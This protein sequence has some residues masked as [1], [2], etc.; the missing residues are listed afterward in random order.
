MSKIFLILSIFFLGLWLIGGSL[1]YANKFGIPIQNIALSGVFPVL[2]VTDGDFKITSRSNFHFRHSCDK[3]VVPWETEKSLK[4]LVKYLDQHPSRNLVLTGN[5]SPV[6]QNDTRYLDLG[7]ARSDAIRNLLI[8]FD[9][10]K[11]DIIIQSK[12]C[13]GLKFNND[14][15]F[16]GVRFS[17]E[18]KID[19]IRSKT[20]EEKLVKTSRTIEKIRPLN[21]YYDNNTEFVQNSTQL[22]AYLGNLN[23]YLKK[24]PTSKVLLIGHTDNVGTSDQ[25]KLL[26]K[27]RAF[28]VKSLME[29]FG[30][31]AKQIKVDY[32]GD[33]RPL[34]S[35][36]TNN[37]RKKNRRVEVR[38]IN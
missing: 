10:K 3:V 23:S 36:A 7:L 37:G 24:H 16:D 29:E 22:N 18:Q 14:L 15:L 1:G 6:E 8:S 11:E 25:N 26:S 20:P 5:Y 33:K 4:T 27:K 19:P 28:T 13:D 31:A 9:A 35:N 12:L 21:L 38:L 32:M 34:V 17:F 30:I 2:N